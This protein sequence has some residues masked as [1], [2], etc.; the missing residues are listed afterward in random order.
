MQFDE[1]R[2]LLHNST[3]QMV[4]QTKDWQF[5]SDNDK[6]INVKFY[7]QGSI[8]QGKQFMDCRKLECIEVEKDLGVFVGKDLI[9]QQHVNETVKKA[10][11]QQA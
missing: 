7:M 8:K 2:M 1:H 6:I 9:F 4:Q 3:D 10:N 11:K 5:K